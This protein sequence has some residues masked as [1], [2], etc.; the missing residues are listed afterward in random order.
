MTSRRIVCPCT[1]PLT[2][3]IFIENE[4]A[5]ST[6]SILWCNKGNTCKHAPLMMVWK[7]TRHAG[8]ETE[9]DWL[10]SELESD[11]QWVHPTRER[12]REEEEE[13]EDDEEVGSSREEQR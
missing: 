1:I 5:T 4:F 10:T 7:G 9:A 11:S 13:E 2:M 3:T 8:S 6:D 12:E